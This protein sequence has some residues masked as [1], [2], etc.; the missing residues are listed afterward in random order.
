MV[1]SLTRL[2]GTANLDLAEDVVQDAFCRALETWKL[3]GIPANP[4][5]W[6]MKTARNR[7]I[8]V[9]RRQRTVREFAPDLAQAAASEWTLAPAVTQLLAAPSVKDDQLRMMFSCCDPRLPEQAQVALILHLLC[10]F[11]VAEVAGAFL[12]SRAATEKRIVRA[13]RVLAG[14]RRLFDLSDRDFSARLRAV[15]RAIYLL[16]NEGYHGASPS[17]PVRRELC[18]EAIRLG[19]LLRAN[20]QTATPATSA[21]CAL[22]FLGAARL[23]ARVDSAG[24]LHS[25]AGQDR[26]QWDRR[27]VAQGQKLLEESAH[28]DEVSEYHLEAAIALEH[29]HAASLE[30][31]NWRHIVDLYDRLLRLRP[32]PVVAL[33]RAIAVGQL[34]GPAR[35]LEELQAIAGSRRLAAY[36]FYHAAFGEFELRSGR[37]QVA[38]GHFEKALSF[39]RNAMERQFLEARIAATACLLEPA[40]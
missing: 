2:F 26:S 21:L 30:A 32:T 28:G 12:S 22:M 10:G 27:F 19:S 34:E 20:P 8:D 33:N 6:L 7:A 9:L 36:P 23:G 35:G 38:R 18:Q 14:A 15:H 1:A 13:K 4:S 29:A 25:L 40:P 24:N 39:A 16:F 11:S 17:E 37:A 5:A 31:T 3:R